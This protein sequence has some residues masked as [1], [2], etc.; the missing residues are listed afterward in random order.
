[1]RFSQAAEAVAARAVEAGAASLAALVPAELAAQ[2]PPEVTARGGREAPFAGA[3]ADTEEV[4]A[5]YP[6][7]AAPAAL[8]ASQAGVA[9][10]LGRL[11]AW[12]LCAATKCECILGLQRAGARRQAAALFTS[13]NL[14]ALRQRCGARGARVYATRAGARV[15]GAQCGCC[16][17]GVLGMGLRVYP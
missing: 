14:T 4:L 9:A 3:A 6:A 16:L 8:A 2:L 10:R 11:E 12:E 1:M 5:A 7:P 15:R 17:Q 13:I